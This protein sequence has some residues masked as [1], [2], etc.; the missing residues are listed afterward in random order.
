MINNDHVTLRGKFCATISACVL[1]QLP[2]S[3]H[4]CKKQLTFIISRCSQEISWMQLLTHQPRQ[5][6]TTRYRPRFLFHPNH[7]TKHTAPSRCP[8]HRHAALGWPCVA[9]GFPQIRARPAACGRSR[10]VIT[11]RHPSPQ[12][13]CTLCTAY[14][15]R[16]WVPAA[17]VMDKEGWQE[18]LAWHAPGPCGS[19]IRAAE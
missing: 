4:S 15:G 1:H 11:P 10:P 17:A 19:L 14:G 3:S 13:C 8:N 12:C 5:I 9:A 7:A 18:G 16:A 6:S 2:M